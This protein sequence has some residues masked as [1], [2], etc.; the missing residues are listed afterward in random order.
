[1]TYR[2]EVVWNREFDFCTY[3]PTFSNL[4]NAIGVAKMMQDSGNGERVKKARVVN[5]NDL[6]IDIGQRASTCRR[7]ASRQGW[8][9]YAD[10]I[11][12]ELAT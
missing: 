6:H 3:G 5:E 11:E 1:M 4:K 8:Q 2:V 9:C 7:L 12:P 10:F